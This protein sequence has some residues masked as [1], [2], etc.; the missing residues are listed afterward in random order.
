MKR[1][2]ALWSSRWAALPASKR[3]TLLTLAV[4]AAGMVLVVFAGEQL[5][6]AKGALRE[7]QRIALQLAQWP[8]SSAPGT[9][10]LSASQ[11]QAQAR[12]AGLTVESLSLEGEHLTL[13]ANGPAGGLMGWLQQVE[14][15][16]VEILSLVL[17]REGERIH[18]QLQLMVGEEEV[19]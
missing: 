7:E 3:R 11:V 4:L 16:Q 5:Q 6:Q 9:R 19:D 10:A 2:V 1:L 18:L 12:Q 8:L 17:E 13:L 15:Q 14:S